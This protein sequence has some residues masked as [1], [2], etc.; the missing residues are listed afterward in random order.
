MD[1]NYLSISL[2]WAK[3]ITA[4]A[5]FLF[6]RLKSGYFCQVSLYTQ[7]AQSSQYRLMMRSTFAVCLIGL[8]AKCLAFAPPSRGTFDDVLSTSTP[9]LVEGDM[10]VPVGHLGTG[11]APEAFLSKKA[12]L[13]PRGIV[14]YKFET[15]EW[16]GV[17]EPVF[18]DSQME[19]ITQALQL[20]MHNVPCIKFM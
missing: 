4:N 20:I 6:V 9:N 13:W 19:N 2:N 14:Y 17:V 3:F 16:E 8:F 5:R 7:F 12:N 18:L 10:A 15:F 1:S 11:I